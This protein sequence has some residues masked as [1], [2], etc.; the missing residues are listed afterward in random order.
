MTEAEWLKCDFAVSMLYFLYKSATNRKL[1]LSRCAWCR[2][3]PYQSADYLTRIA[4][5][6]AERYADGQAS[7]EE[8]QAALEWAVGDAKEC[9]DVEQNNRYYRGAT[10]PREWD[11]LKCSVYRDIFGPLPFRTIAIDQTWLTS[12]ITSLAATIYADG[13]FGHMPILADALEEAGC[14]NTDILSHCRQSGVH[15]RGCWV[16]DLLLRKN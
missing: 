11:L 2:L 13:N 16:V 10:T 15:V 3:H 9:L 4:V 5:E 6:V 12:S 1:R 14:T 8:R 7:E